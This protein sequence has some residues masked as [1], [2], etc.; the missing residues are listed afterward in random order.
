MKN[1]GEETFR[2]ITIAMVR[3]TCKVGQIVWTYAGRDFYADDLIEILEGGEEAD[4][5]N[6]YMQQL[7]LTSIQ[8]LQHVKT[9]ADIPPAERLKSFLYLLMRDRLPTADV[10]EC[11]QQV[12]HDDASGLETKYTAAGLA[13]YADE[14]AG[15]ILGNG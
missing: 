14:L 1:D 15:R 10:A 7:M 5:G 12:E 2:E 11:V 9:G 3:Q 8:L 4:L 13:E 6:A